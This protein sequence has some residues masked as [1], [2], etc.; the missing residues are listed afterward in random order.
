MV[1][2]AAHPNAQASGYVLEH[3]KV[4]AD[5]IGRALLPGENVHHL[6]GVKDD[7]RRENL[8]LWVSMQPSGQ[9]TPDLINYALEILDRYGLDPADA[10]RA[11]SA[12]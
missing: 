9:R 3:V 10:R 11:G 12:T 4:M 6:N 7:N 5:D 2:D 8:E 1:Y